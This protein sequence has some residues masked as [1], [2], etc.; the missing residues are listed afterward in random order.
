MVLCGNSSLS[1]INHN[2]SSICIYFIIH[3]ACN[4]HG[5]DKAERGRPTQSQRITHEAESTKSRNRSLPLQPAVH[6]LV[7]DKRESKTLDIKFYLL[8]I[9]AFLPAP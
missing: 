3:S 7:R 4:E 9:S 8:S 1:E 6:D 5:H 2:Q